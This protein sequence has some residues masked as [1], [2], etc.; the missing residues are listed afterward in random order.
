MEGRSPQ[1]VDSIK[2]EMSPYGYQSNNAACWYKVRVERQE[3]R[4]P[5]I[6]VVFFCDLKIRQLVLIIIDELEL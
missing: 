2:E 6:E 3:V 5:E 1:K 4:L